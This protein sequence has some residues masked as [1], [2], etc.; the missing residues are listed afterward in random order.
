MNILDNIIE[1]K[2]AE[3]A[4]RKIKVPLSMLRDAPGYNRRCLALSKSICTA[5]SS[6][7]IAEFKRKSPSKGFIN[8]HADVSEITKA[9]TSGGAAGL[10]VLTD[11]IF[12]GGSADDLLKARINPV[13]ILRKDFII[14]AYQVTEAK[15]M[16]ADTVLLIAS[17]LSPA[18][19]KELAAYAVSLG[20]EVLLELHDEKEL[21]HCCDDTLLIGINNRNLKDFSVDIN[22]SLQMSKLIVQ[23]KILIAESG[24]TDPAMIS[25]FRDAGFKGFLIGETFMKTDDPGKAFG[26][27]AKKIRHGKY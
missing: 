3:V 8:E 12:F 7:I 6:G 20:M 15:A 10:S 16:G 17:C 26:N 1:Y 18:A 25:A 19:V 9:Y 5:G 2:K 11:K 27:F 24:I 23:G 22:A 14:D 4:E 13:P 21:E